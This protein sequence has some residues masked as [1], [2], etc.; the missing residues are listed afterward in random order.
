MQY[1]DGVVR[2]SRTRNLRMQVRSPRT[3][4]VD[5]HAAI[6]HPSG[7][8]RRGVLTRKTS[9]Y[10]TPGSTWT[11]TPRSGDADRAKP[12]SPPPSEH[13]IASR[14]SC[15]PY[16]LILSEICHGQEPRRGCHAAGK[17]ACRSPVSTQTRREC[18]QVARR[19]RAGLCTGGASADD[20]E[21]Q[22]RGGRGPATRGEAR[23]TGDRGFPIPNRSTG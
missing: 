23:G 1:E 8:G 4:P 20:G 12:L 9:R 14:R 7:L 11:A 10:A 5:G 3:L 2:R 22:S 16:P 13:S 18:E 15:W 21:P 17:I 19:G 6:L